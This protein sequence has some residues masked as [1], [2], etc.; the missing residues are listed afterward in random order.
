MAKTARTPS[1]A[2]ADAA[3][4]ES[5]TAATDRASMQVLRLR[6]LGAGLFTDVDNPTHRVRIEDPDDTPA[7]RL[8]AASFSC[9]Q[10]TQLLR[11]VEDLC[12][13]SRGQVDPEGISALCTL[14]RREIERVG[15]C[16]DNDVVPVSQE[17][18]Q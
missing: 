16:L 2:R 14:M 4:P 9:Y 7:T 18:R 10:L 6:K 17:A 13:V 5:T 8:D 11:L 15:D 12:N 1:A 3:L